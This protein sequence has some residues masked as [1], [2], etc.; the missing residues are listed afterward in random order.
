MHKYEII[1][2]WERQDDIYIAEAPEL[3]GCKAHGKNYDEALANIKD[4]IALW[5]ETANEF[6]D[7]I[8]EAKGAKLRYA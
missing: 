6:G 3:A 7:Y 2:Y 8:P 4:A 5:I 1:I